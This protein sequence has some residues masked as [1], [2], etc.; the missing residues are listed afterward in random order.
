MN[1]K[2]IFDCVRS[3]MGGSLNQ[4]EVAQLDRAIDEAEGV[5]RVTAPRAGHSINQAGL[6]LIKT[7]EGRKLV[8]YPDPATGGEPW[9]IG[10]GATY[11]ADGSKVK[12][13]DRIT[14]A[15]ADEL[16][17]AH[18]AEFAEG[19]DKMLLIETS[20]NQFAAMVSLAFNI[21][22]AAF[23][24]STLLRKHNGGDYRGAADEFLRWNRA[25]GR[26]MRGLT[27]RRE[28]ERELYLS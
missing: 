8:A 26:V 13:G 14:E 2:P 1:R 25:A 21:G 9:T 11:Y 20:D 17:A 22:M 3:L 18:V 7:F 28:A 6:D 24:R 5:I 16:L 19:V 4:G 15:E 23:S 27:R 12:R 10:T